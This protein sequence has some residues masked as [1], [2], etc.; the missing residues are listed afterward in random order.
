VPLCTSCRRDLFFS[1]RRDGR[2]SG[3]M[4]NF[5]RT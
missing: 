2:R 4:L 1:Y 3:R 5:V